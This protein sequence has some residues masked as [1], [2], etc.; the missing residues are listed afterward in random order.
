MIALGV[1]LVIIGV[2]SF[3]LPMIG[4]PIAVFDGYQPWVGIIIAAVGLITVIFGARRRIAAPSVIDTTDQARRAGGLAR[5]HHRGGHRLNFDSQSRRLEPARRLDLR[6]QG[7][8]RWGLHLAVR[9][10]PDHVPSHVAYREVEDGPELEPELA[11]VARREVLWVRGR[12]VHAGEHDRRADGMHVRP[13]FG[14][15]RRPPL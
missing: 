13:P 2:G 5:H 4:Y 9:D 12:D 1:L 8:R 10:E 14:N 11:E 7:D 15:G 6:S 3:V